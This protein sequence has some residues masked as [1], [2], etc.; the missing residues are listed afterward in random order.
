MDSQYV[1]LSCVLETQSKNIG[2]S[3]AELE[4][5]A[6]FLPRSAL[7]EKFEEIGKGIRIYIYIVYIELIKINLAANV[8]ST[9]ACSFWVS[10]NKVKHDSFSAICPRD[11]KNYTIL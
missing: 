4:Q 5:K 2:V 7:G 9:V 3:L 1:Y 6:L 8:L 11:V 10:R